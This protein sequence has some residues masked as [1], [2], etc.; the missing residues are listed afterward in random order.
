MADLIMAGCSYVVAAWVFI[1]SGRWTTDIFIGSPSWMPRIVAGALILLASILL[2]AAVKGRGAP[3]GRIGDRRDLARVSLALGAALAYLALLRPVGF[4]ISSTLLT[5]V[6]QWLMGQRR[7]GVL[8]VVSL[9]L[10]LA[11]YL[12]FGKI[13]AVPLP[14]GILSF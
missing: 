13:L 8:A 1:E 2:A 11:C 14:A 10:P 7:Y 12:L 4:L 9:T 6:L 3:L 5:A